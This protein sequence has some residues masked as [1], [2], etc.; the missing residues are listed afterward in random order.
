[1]AGLGE[2]A[3]EFPSEL[4]EIPGQFSAEHVRL[5]PE[6]WKRYLLK[7]VS[8]MWKLKTNYAINLLILNGKWGNSFY[9]V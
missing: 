3:N 4:K 5:S 8:G 6:Y 9:G 2:D 7:K 1:M